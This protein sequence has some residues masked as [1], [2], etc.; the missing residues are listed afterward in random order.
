MQVIE[1]PLAEIRPYANNPRINEGAVESLAKII[2]ELG[3]RNPVLLNRDHVIIEGHTRW[4]ACKK[5][6]METMPCIVEEDLTP[7]Q[8]AALRIADNKVAEIAEWDEDKLKVEMKLLQDAGFDLS[9]LAFHDDELDALLGDDPLTPGQT[10]E[11]EVPETPVEAVSK[12][13]EVY[14]LGQHR[15]LCGDSTKAEDVKKLT[16]E[17]TVDL[18]LTDPPYNV[19]YEGSNGLTIQNDSMED[20]KFRE[21]LRSAF[22]AAEKT[23]KPGATGYVFHADSEGYNFR[24]ACLDVGLTIPQCLIWKKNAL[25]L[26]RQDYQWIHEP[27]LVVRKPGAAHSWYGDRKQTTV[28]EYNK[29]KKNDVHP[30]LA[31]D[32]KIVTS[33]GLKPVAKVALGDKVL[34]CDGR[35]HSVH[36]VTNHPY[37]EKIYSI[38]TEGAFTADRA[39]HNHKY[40]VAEENGKGG[41]DIRWV[42]AED[43]KEG[44]LLMTPKMKD[45]TFAPVSELDAW[46]LGYYL[47]WGT[48][49][50]SFRNTCRVPGF[51]VPPEKNH[52][53]GKLRMWG[54]SDKVAVRKLREGEGVSV[55]VA[56][57]EK[58]EL[59]AAY[60]G[61]R[62]RLIAEDVFAWKENLRRSFLKGVIDGCG[63]RK[64][65]VVRLEFGCPALASQIMTLARSVGYHPAVC[66]ADG[67]D[68]LSYNVCLK[69]VEKSVTA[70]YCGAEYDLNPIVSITAR[71]YDGEVWNLGCEGTHTFLTANGMTK[72]T[73]KPVEMLVY[74][75]KNS[76]Q[77]GDMVLDTFGGSGSTLIACEETGRVCRTME[78]DPK[79][80]DVIRKRWAE[81]KFGEGCDWQKSTAPEGAAE[82]AAESVPTTAA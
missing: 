16:G 40:L 41:Y 60:I 35:F 64:G 15:L 50:K 54:G 9:V 23:L 61:C 45:G 67:G 4:E 81:F 68:G 51:V 49:L 55:M 72:N 69:P 44:D 6:G 59:C 75:I 48:I 74:L 63:E 66:P 56:E 20:T 80:C 22:A 26:G 34:G 76:S 70:S 2:K 52:L 31:P 58:G 28:M 79:Y 82:P 29:P 25:V 14:V 19:A 8:E 17:K 30:C 73:M 21:F 42:K 10:D 38:R 5:L 3:F 1:L 39:T 13:G 65:G 62:P 11:D 37:D 77:R 57:P 47:T 78:L 46:C 32:T 27:C 71:D 18:W 12:S 33:E 53:V 7:E 43:L 36:L 24:G